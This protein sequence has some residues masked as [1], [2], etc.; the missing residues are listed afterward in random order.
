VEENDR[1]LLHD[2]IQASSRTG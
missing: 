2:I 1:G